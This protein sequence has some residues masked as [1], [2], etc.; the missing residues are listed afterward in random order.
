MHQKENIELKKIVDKL[1][2]RLSPMNSEVCGP[3]KSQKDI[4]KKK[5]LRGKLRMTSTVSH[6]TKNRLADMN[7]L[8]S[9]Q[10]LL[11]WAD[12]RVIQLNKLPSH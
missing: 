7:W 5:L 3:S 1:Q 4:E 9:P 6:Y 11:N 2:Q 8:T 12:K 10:N